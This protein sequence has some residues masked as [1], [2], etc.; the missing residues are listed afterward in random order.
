MK[1]KKV[2]LID[3]ENFRKISDAIFYKELKKEF[4]PINFDFS[5]FFDFILADIKPEKK[6]T[7]FSKIKYYSQTGGK[8]K[9]LIKRQR[10]LRNILYHGGFD[11]CIAGIVRMQKINNKIVF[12]EK[13]VDVKI[14][15][16][17]IKYSLIE[18]VSQLIICSSD[19]DLQPA[20]KE[21]RNTGTKFI[22]LG[23][24]EKPNKGLMYTTHQTILIK[25]KTL[26]RF[27]KFK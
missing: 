5:N 14:A 24:E 19:S 6:I 9:E 7:Y 21:S 22:Y 26:F 20:I 15:V 17:I 18:K 13:G 4:N 2:L 27:Y 10:K 16:D 12:N 1:D 23:F 25:S 3:G 8:S 11:F